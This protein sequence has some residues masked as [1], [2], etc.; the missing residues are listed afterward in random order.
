MIYLDSCLV[1]YA[2]EAHPTFGPLVDEAMEG[3]E[4]FAIS[5][6]V[7]MECLVRPI[8]AAN[9]MLVRS[10]EAAFASLVQLRVS[11]V[12]FREAAEL[13]ARFKLKTPDALHLAC[14]QRYGCEA[15]WTHDDR[16]AQASRGLARNVLKA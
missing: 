9:R 5:P 8:A 12:V 6:L 16:L 1:I 14:A 10:Y 3:R 2:V 15:F 11:E 13:R 7:R 4:D